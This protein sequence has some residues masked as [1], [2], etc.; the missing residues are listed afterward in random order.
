MGLMGYAL[1][2]VPKTMWRNA[3]PGQYLE[4]LHYRV[5]EMEEEV[6]ESI[7]EFKKVAAYVMHLKRE[8]KEELVLKYCEAA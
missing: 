4:Y 1:V 7:S 8:S 3:D 6:D 2:E 5:A